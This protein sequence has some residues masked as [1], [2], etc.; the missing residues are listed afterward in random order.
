MHGDSFF[1][2][3]LI[4][5]AAAVISVPLAKRFGLGSVLGYLIAGAIIGPAVLGLVGNEG[6][7]VMHF[8][9]FG[10]VM[11]LFV[12]GLELEP[13]L[14]WRLR[15][16]ILGLGG[17]QVGLTALA[18]LIITL[19]LGFPW[20]QGLAIGLTLAMSS[21]AIV[22]QSLQEKGWSK[23]PAG[24]QSFSVLLF[25]DIAVIPILAVFPLLAD[26][27][28]VS[29]A[30]H[31]SPAAQSGWM[32]TVMVFGAV[33][34]VALGG[35]FIVQPVFHYIGRTRMREIFTAAALLLVI[36]AATLMQTVGLSPALGTFLAGVVLANSEYRHELESDIEPFKGLLLGLFFISVGASINFPLIASQP[37]SIA[38]LVVSILAVKAVILAGIGILSKLPL[39]QNV[40]F[41]FGLSQVGEFAFV[42]YSFALQQHILPEETVGLLVAA[43]AL[44]MASTPLLLAV[45]EKVLLNRLQPVQQ[46]H[47]EADAVEEHHPVIIAGFG[48]FGNIAG[49]L[50]RAN[51]IGCTILDHDADRIEVLK[52]LGIKAYYGDATRYDL[53]LSA[54]AGEAKAMVIALDSEEKNLVLVH[55]AR[56]HFPHLK[57]FVRAFD[58]SDAFDLKEAGADAVYRDTLDTALRL[59]SDALSHLG[60]RAFTAERNARFFR[61]YDEHALEELAKHRKDSTTYLSVARQ[62]IAEL[63][64]LIQQDIQDGGGDKDSG[65]DSDSLRATVQNPKPQ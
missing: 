25:Q 39:D 35:R 60:I 9:E 50:L 57:L 19:L 40:L 45:Y 63:E 10:V 14:L 46:P 22:L 54:G 13:A 58:R 52:K 15:T 23:S 2:Q 48:R 29:A 6:A 20:K 24:Q 64:S 16:S 62:R 65:W 59:G 32:Q 26:G 30:A 8:A 4:Y 51:G 37:G 33:A 36:A 43:T 41:A 5:L 34:A 12:V 44:S 11:M 18:I 21:T 3:A 61:R 7:D 55:T 28:P 17:A 1:I 49:R 31:A 42:L 38:L 27:I 53:L 56:K 47:R